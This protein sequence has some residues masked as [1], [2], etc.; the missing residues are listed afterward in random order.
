[1]SNSENLDLMKSFIQ[2]RENENLE[3]K[4]ELAQLKNKFLN[5]SSDS[6]KTE[7]LVNS[8]PVEYLQ[9]YKKPEKSHS[10]NQLIVAS[11]PPENSDNIISNEL[12]SGSSLSLIKSNVN[13]TK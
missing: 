12:K 7:F 4:K 11:K 8:K 5:S 9:E 3:I 6:N 2:A 13:R 10:S 1:M